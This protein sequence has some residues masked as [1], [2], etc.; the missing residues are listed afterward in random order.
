MSRDV[1][2]W[3][4]ASGRRAFCRL[5]RFGKGI[6]PTHLPS[7][8]WVITS[9]YLDERH[10]AER[11]KRGGKGDSRRNTAGSNDCGRLAP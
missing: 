7:G 5:E 6:D 11:G 4:E 3:G 9:C 2:H 10:T 8:L 1:G